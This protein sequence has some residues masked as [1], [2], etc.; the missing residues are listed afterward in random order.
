MVDREDED[1]ASTIRVRAMQ[2]AHDGLPPLFAD[3]NLDIAP[4]SRC[5]LV[6]TMDLE[7]RGAKL[8]ALLERY[9]FKVMYPLKQ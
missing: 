7:D 4:G 2:L 6:G 9:L 5:L 8:L 3:F 1:Q